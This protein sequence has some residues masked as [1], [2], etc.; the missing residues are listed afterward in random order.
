MPK[1]RMIL[2]LLMKNTGVF[3]NSRQFRLEAVGE[4]PWVKSYLDFNSIDEL[5][6]LNVDRKTKDIG[7]FAEKML[8]LS[9]EC[10]VPISAGGGVTSLQH[11]ETL[12]NA[13]A[14]KVV[15]NS[16]CYRREEFIGEAASRYGSQC[17]IASV[18]V[19][20]TANGSY[21]CVADNGVRP[22]GWYVVDWCTRLEALGAGEVLIRS[23]ENDGC[24]RG[25]DIDLLRL[26][27]SSINIPLIAAGG[28]G[29]LEHLSQGVLNGKADAVS[30]GNLFHYIGKNLIQAK[31]HLSNDGL[32]FPVWNFS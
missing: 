7:L 15:V 29:E 12:L 30:A 8:D 19:S 23:I 3:F 18:D 27:S 2:T 9:R 26:V 10:F 28:V 16:E 4:L 1:H 20:P 32:D 13:G 17:I 5:I 14:D 21:I 31:M 25:Y 11:F 6:L 24:A 22:T